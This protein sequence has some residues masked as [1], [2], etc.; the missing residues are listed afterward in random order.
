MLQGLPLLMLPL[1]S[2]V[3]LLPLLDLALLVLQVLLLGPD[4]RRRNEGKVEEEEERGGEAVA[5]SP[6]T[7]TTLA[8]APLPPAGAGAPCYCY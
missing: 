6:D 3:A 7:C 1:D 2:G 8:S 5:W 4:R